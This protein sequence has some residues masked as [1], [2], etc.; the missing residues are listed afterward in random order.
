MEISSSEPSDCLESPPPRTRGP[1][2]QEHPTPG[3]PGV[4]AEEMEVPEANPFDER[5]C[6]QRL[7]DTR[8]F[9]AEKEEFVRVY[10]F[11]VNA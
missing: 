3:T 9:L 11:E 1:G 10:A 4:P 2:L 8:D 5:E 6:P 7:Y